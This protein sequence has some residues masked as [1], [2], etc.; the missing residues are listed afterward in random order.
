MSLEFDDKGK[1]YTD[2]VAK[3]GVPAMIQT[4]THRI[5]GLIHLRPDERVSDALDRDEGFL[6]VT[7]AIIF[8]SQGEIL[9]QAEFLSVRR[10][11]IVWLIP[12]ENPPARQSRAG[13][14]A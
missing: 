7:G 11:Q 13:E 2:I 5:S 8:G 1:F 3:V 4:V 10:E 6:P 14:E 9:F 12:Q